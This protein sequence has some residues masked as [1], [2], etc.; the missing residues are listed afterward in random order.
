MKMRKPLSL[1][2]AGL[3]CVP[4]LNVGM[5]SQTIQKKV[6]NT[7]HSKIIIS[8]FPDDS[9]NIPQKFY[10]QGYQLILNERWSE[11]REHL[12]RVAENFPRSKYNEPAQYWIAFT[13]KEDGQQNAQQAYRTFIGAYPQ[14]NYYDDAIAD[15]DELLHEPPEPAEVIVPI[16]RMDGRGNVTSDSL[17]VSYKH[18]NKGFS[19]YVNVAPRVPSLEKLFQLEVRMVGRRSPVSLREVIPPDMQKQLEVV[20]STGEVLDGETFHH[21][22]GVA[23]DQTRPE[24][25][26]EAAVFSLS[27]NDTFD[28]LP[29]FADLVKR[30]T[31]KGLQFYAF[32][33]FRQYTKDRDK[34][35][36]TMIKLFNELPPERSEEREMIFYSIAD[37]G[38]DK[39]IDFLIDIAESKIESELTDQAIYYLG[40]LG[41][42][43]ARTALRKVYKAK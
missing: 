1:I 8:Q 43:K 11:A 12:T 33:N 14:S 37:V 26:R 42:E 36:S 13:L 18:K 35:V 16:I 22:E 21:L 27:I 41:S 38:N 28:I 25:L 39:A 20:I 17:R 2:I 10:K 7:R 4:L 32:E 5:L 6:K 24:E 31:N 15:L 9:N 3:L 29:L 23:L 40:S 34:A 19:Y 30:D